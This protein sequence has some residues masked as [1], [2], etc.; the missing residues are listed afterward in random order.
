[1]I[2]V[3]VNLIWRKTIVTSSIHC[4][5]ERNLKIVELILFVA[6]RERMETHTPYPG[7]GPIPWPR[8]GSGNSRAYLNDKH[9]Q[10][11]QSLIF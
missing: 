8:Y 10:K 9:N 7:T 2:S 1:M 11:E 5:L 4:R 6:V 3:S